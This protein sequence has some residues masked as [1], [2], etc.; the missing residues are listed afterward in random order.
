SPYHTRNPYPT[1]PKTCKVLMVC[2]LQ[3]HGSRYPTIH[4]SIKIQNALSKIKNAIP[5]DDTLIFVQDYK[6]HLLENSLNEF[7]EHE[8]FQSGQEFKKRYPSLFSRKNQNENYSN[9]SV[10]FVRASSS[11]RVIESSKK[12]LIGLDLKPNFEFNDSDILVISENPGVTL[13]D[14]NCPNSPDLPYSNQWSKFFTRSIIKRLNSKAIGLN[15]DEIDVISLMQLCCFDSLAD[16]KY[17]RFCK[18]FE[19]SDWIEY[20]IDLDKLYKH[21]YGNELGAVQGVG[22]VAEL[23]SRLT[24]NAS[25]VKNDKTQVN[26]TLAQSKGTFPLNR[27]VYLDFSHDNQMISIISALGIK[28]EPL[29]SPNGP[30][31]PNRGW[32]MSSMVPFAS[33]LTFEKVHCD[34]DPNDQIRILLN[35]DWIP[36]EF[37]KGYKS[38]FCNLDSFVNSQNF[39]R[40]NGNGLYDLVCFYCLSFPLIIFVS[41]CYHYGKLIQNQIP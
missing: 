38:G 36:L 4:V 33:R 2:Q 41:V 31:L 7:G 3:R 8:S 17:S 13:D 30:P 9:S 35:D 25:Y 22:Y 28:M 27:K 23:L 32:R 11:E 18:L 15:L 34:D 16:Q 6:Y 24:V 29:L 40:Q 1:L 19:K 12:F 10:M 26:H 39:T 21:G 5:I 14:N 37:C 20:Y